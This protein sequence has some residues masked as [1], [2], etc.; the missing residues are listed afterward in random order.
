MLTP[1]PMS[2]EED[3]PRREVAA[4]NEGTT[5]FQIHYYPY[6]CTYIYPKTPGK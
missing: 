3:I 1:I 4:D 2:L 5:S 6:Q